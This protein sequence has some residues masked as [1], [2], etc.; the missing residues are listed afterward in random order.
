MA[1]GKGL[2]REAI[3]AAAEIIID[4][5]GWPALTL[6]S[7]ASALQIKSPSLYAHFDGLEGIREALALRGASAMHAVLA[8]AASEGKGE[9]RLRA[10]C[11]AYRRF[12]KN[13]P[14]L[15]AAIQRGSSPEEGT[16][17]ALAQYEIVRVV[18]SAIAAT[19][20]A[21]R[22]TIHLVRAMRAALHGFTVL[23]LEGGFGLPR[24]VE[25][26]FERLVDLLIDGISRERPV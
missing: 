4:R 15:Y 2:D 24:S 13:H 5:H 18:L 26:S 3:L 9:A 6:A 7:L 19:G 22:D 12:A 23:E 8:A 20:V 21:E 11:Y 25:T 10:I 14:G 1:R 17:L 16:A